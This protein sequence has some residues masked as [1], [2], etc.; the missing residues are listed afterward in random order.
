MAKK[1]VRNAF[2]RKALNFSLL[3]LFVTGTAAAASPTIDFYL[4]MTVLCLVGAWL[5]ALILKWLFGE[6]N[7]LVSDFIEEHRMLKKMEANTPAKKE[8]DG[9]QTG[10]TR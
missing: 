7:D 10:T 4:S 9:R 8:K 1:N 5:L 3:F 6:G 2:D